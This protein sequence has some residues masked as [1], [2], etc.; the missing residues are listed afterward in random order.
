MNQEDQNQ[1]MKNNPQFEDSNY[2]Q[3][4]RV[5]PLTTMDQIKREHTELMNKKEARNKEAAKIAAEKEVEKQKIE[6]DKKVE[7]AIEEKRTKLNN[8]NEK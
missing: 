2:Q 3:S 8:E 4:M 6:F 5:D 7:E 1:Q